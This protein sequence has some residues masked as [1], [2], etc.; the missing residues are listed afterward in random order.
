MSDDS[1]LN[2]EEREWLLS[3]MS[4]EAEDSHPTDDTEFLQQKITWDLFE[5][6]F[7]SP[8]ASYLN[9]QIEPFSPY[10]KIPFKPGESVGEALARFL[11]A[12]KAS[13]Q[14]N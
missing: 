11:A 9:H 13:A 2:P 6:L 14:N 3:N 8:V 12:K 7:R 10:P 4:E 1:K 5:K